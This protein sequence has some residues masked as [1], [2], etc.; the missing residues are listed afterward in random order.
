[1]NRFELVTSTFR[2]C[3]NFV[4]YLKTKLDLKGFAFQIFFK[5]PGL[6]NA[7]SQTPIIG[8]IG[9]VIVCCI[10]NHSLCQSS[11]TYLLIFI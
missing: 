3:Y 8:A 7:P 5:S 1:M 9:D 11:L 4:N 10:K 6:L 2:F